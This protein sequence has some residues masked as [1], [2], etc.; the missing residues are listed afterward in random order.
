MTSNLKHD[1]QRLRKPKTYS[2]SRKVVP[3]LK[4]AA[5]YSGEDGA[6]CCSE[7]NI[8]SYIT[9]YSRRH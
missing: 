2:H 7:T 1:L 6:V 5:P 3:M 8:G 9:S 4:F